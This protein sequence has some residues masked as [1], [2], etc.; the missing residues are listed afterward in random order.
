[1]AY[2]KY[3]KYIN[4]IPYCRKLKCICQCSFCLAQYNC[5]VNKNCSNRKFRLI[6]DA[7][8][9]YLEGA[10]KLTHSLKSSS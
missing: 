4:E 6:K 1:M 10:R 3:V 7:A 8:E 5:S 2:C 9:V